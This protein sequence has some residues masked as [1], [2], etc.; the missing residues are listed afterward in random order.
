MERRAAQFRADIARTIKAGQD[1]TQLRQEEALARILEHAEKIAA[2]APDFTD[3][4][5]DR[6]AVALRGAP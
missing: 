2:A 1:T 5:R 6:L 3:E 4:Q